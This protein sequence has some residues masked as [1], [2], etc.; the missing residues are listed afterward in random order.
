MPKSF[1]TIE[2]EFAGNILNWGFAESRDRYEEILAESSF[3]ISTSIH[4]FQGLSVIEAAD[5]GC[6]PILPEG[7]LI[8]RFSLMNSSTRHLLISWLKPSSVLIF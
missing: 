4:D 1:A 5:A 3:I 2:K 8:L 6:T 7:S